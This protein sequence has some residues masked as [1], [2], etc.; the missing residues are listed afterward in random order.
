M[1]KIPLNNQ[2]IIEKLE[3]AHWY[4]QPHILENFHQTGTRH[5]EKDQKWFTSDEYFNQIRDMKRNHDGFPEAIQSWSMQYSTMKPKSD[6]DAKIKQEVYR[7]SSDFMAWFEGN[8]CMKSNA[9]FAIY[10]PGGFISWHNNANAAAYNCILTW[11]ETGDGYFKWWDNKKEEFV[12][13]HDEPGWQCR[14]G[15]FGSYEDDWNDLV[16][17]CAAT[18]CWRMTISFTF[19][20][21]EQSQMMQDWLVE[22]LMADE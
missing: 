22:D 3:E 7:K 9:L 8:Y 21:S 11:S 4:R 16:Y 20:R 1:R 6:G 13:W 12:Y 17:H 14:L 18:D 2:T 5:G 19:D 10:P 15:Y